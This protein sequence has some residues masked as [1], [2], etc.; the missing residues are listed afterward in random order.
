MNNYT[1]L[2]VKRSCINQLNGNTVTINSR[3]KNIS[4]SSLVMF[5]DFLFNYR[6]T[7]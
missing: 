1:Y 7:K 2:N 4:I 3:Y 5:P 6:A